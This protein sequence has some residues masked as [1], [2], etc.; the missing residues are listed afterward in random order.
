MTKT[1]IALGALATVAGIALISLYISEAVVARWQE[2]DQSLL[3]WYLPF[4]FAGLMLTGGGLATVI[5]LIRR[6]N[7]TN[8]RNS[9]R[10]RKKPT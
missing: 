10:C 6:L 2:A 1:G 9:K 8:E 3:F 7:A 5:A 4:L